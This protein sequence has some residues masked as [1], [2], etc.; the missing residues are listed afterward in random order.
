MPDQLHFPWISVTLV[1]LVIAALAVWRERSGDRARTLS[2]CALAVSLGVLLL[3]N[4]DARL[5]GTEGAH[6]EPWSGTPLAGWFG[7]DIFNAIPLALFG[8]LALGITVFAPRRKVTPHWLSGVLVVTTGTLVAYAAE[9]LVVMGVGWAVSA[10]PFLFRRFFEVP[11]ESEIPRLLR[12]THLVSIAALIAGIYL[13]AESRTLNLEDWQQAL[14]PGAVALELTG[15]ER[16]GF[17]LVVAAVFL[18]KGIWP[19]HSWI[20]TSFERGPMLP[21]SLLVN[22]HLGAFVV[23]RVVLPLLSGMESGTVRVLGDL[24]LLTAAYTAL[25]ALVEPRPRRMLALISVS[26]GSFLLVGL[27]STNTAG[28]AGALIHWQVVS[29]STLILAAVYSGI[30]A[31]IGRE[32]DNTR[33][34]GLAYGAPRLAVFFAMGGLTLV[35][36]PLTLGFC[37]ED[38]LLN[39]TLSTYPYLGFIMP[40]VTAFNAFSFLRLFARLFLGKPGVEV[41]GLSDALPRERWVLTAAVLFLVLGGLFPRT[42]LRLPAAAAERLAVPAAHHSTGMHA[43]LDR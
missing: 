37:A 5:V 27:S 38:L 8:T 42:L 15:G 29:V 4:L 31:R 18:R 17:W 33:Y 35:G 23:V 34:L 7:I 3:G 30:E 9:N 12:A 11:G 39:G 28:V 16:M 2:T 25:L 14:R 13:L 24:G 10:V 20:V 26:Q 32:L 1:V 21:L 41:R 19:F 22:G 40:V 43:K 6:L 36:L